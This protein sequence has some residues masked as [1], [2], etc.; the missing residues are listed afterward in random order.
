M[1]PLK[2][3]PLSVLLMAAA[4]QAAAELEVTGTVERSG[5]RVLVRSGDDRYELR[6]DD[7]AMRAFAA[8]LAGEEVTVR[9]ELNPSGGRLIVNPESILRRESG[10]RVSVAPAETVPA[11]YEEVTSPAESTPPPDGEVYIDRTD[12]RNAAVRN[13]NGAS[14]TARYPSRVERRKRE[15]RTQRRHDHASEVLVTPGGTVIRDNP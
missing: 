13:P 8:A 6:F 11:S 15:V 9:G 4:A 14:D 5:T 3:F 7:K 1:T 2:L 12:R 10:Q